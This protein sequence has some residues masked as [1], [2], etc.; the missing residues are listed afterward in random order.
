M[1]RRRSPVA[2]ITRLRRLFASSNGLRLAL[3]SAAAWIAIGPTSPAL[4]FDVS[5]P[6]VNTNGVISFNSSATLSN[7]TSGSAGSLSATLAVASGGT[8]LTSAADDNVMV[9]NG[10]TWQS[11]A[12]TTC[13][14]AGK[15]VTYDASSNAFGCN[16]ISAGATPVIATHSETKIDSSGDTTLYMSVSGQLS[17]TESEMQTPFQSGTYGNLI[18]RASGTVGGTSMV[19]TLGHGT[20]GSA[21][22]YTSKPTVTPT[23][24]TAVE[25]T[26]NTAALS[27]NDCMVY[28]V[29]ITGN[30]N[31]VY[32]S[33]SLERTA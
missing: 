14:G 31:G 16:T 12:V 13:T 6:I 2:V 18:C 26:S 32:L 9:G 23:A 21:A 15:A 28:K 4:A 22:T 8:N 19:V 11:K 33:C 1:R 3:A 25:D 17:A 29:A 5:D 10:T 24:A 30:I 7:N 27:A 20:C